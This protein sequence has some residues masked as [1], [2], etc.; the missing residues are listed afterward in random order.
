MYYARLNHNP[1][2]ARIAT[3][4][5]A[6]KDK[7]A[8]DVPQKCASMTLLATW[9][10]R[11]FDAPSYGMRDD[12]PLFYIAE[13]ISHFDLIAVQEVREDLGAL[14]KVLAILGRDN[15]DYIVS[16][17]SEG[18]P[19]NRE[20]MAFIYD[21]RSVSF[22]RKAGEV[23]MP[24]IEV[25]EGRKTLRYDPA[26]QLY[27][28]PFMCSFRTGWSHLMLC[29]VHIM[30]GKDEPNNP[31]RVKEIRM[32][33]DLLAKRARSRKAPENMVLLGDFNIYNPEDST[34]EALTAAG[35]EIDESL[36]SLPQSNISTKEKRFYDQIAIYP[37]KHRFE[38]SGRANVFDYYDVVYRPED[39]A[40][41]A[42]KMG[43][44]Y[45]TTSSG[46]PRKN[47]SLYYKTYW[48]TFQ[49][50]DHLPMWVQIKTDFSRDYLAEMQTG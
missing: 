42:A 41:Y 33:A 14:Y 45:T 6:L 5:L 9:N 48:R 40:I 31:K 32:I 21:K 27:R 28:T 2:K 25:K 11:E 18:T 30:Y 39:E 20:R 4:L 22:T 23:V 38:P 36:Q 7:L 34:M 10:I 3:R 13:I 43:D 19:G 50:S 26:T 16:D 15:W 8:A 17:V 24:A 29:T 46:K 1:D 44:S 47:K 35:F 49:M 12:E 37:H